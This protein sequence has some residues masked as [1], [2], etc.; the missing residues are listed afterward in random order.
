MLLFYCASLTVPELSRDTVE[1][2]KK[3]VDTRQKKMESTKAASKAGWE[4][5]VDKLVAGEHRSVCQFSN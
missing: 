4:V 5:E 2:L 3:K 1:S